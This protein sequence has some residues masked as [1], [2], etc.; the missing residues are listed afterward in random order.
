MRPRVALASETIRTLGFEF[1]RRIGSEANLETGHLCHCHPVFRGG[2][3]F[4]G[5]R[6]AHL[7]LACQACRAEAIARLDQIVAALPVRL[8]LWVLLKQ[9]RLLCSSAMRAH[10][11]WPA[12][13]TPSGA[14]RPQRSLALRSQAI[15]GG[16][17]MRQSSEVRVYAPIMEFA[18]SG[19]SAGTFTVVLIHRRGQIRRCGRCFWSRGYSFDKRMWLRLRQVRYGSKADLSV[20]AGCFRAGPSARD[21]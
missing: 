1:A 21:A 16:S 5:H 6:Q 14:C 19:S 20:A 10:H 3:G 18:K 7:G 12:P 11:A 17:L 4:H 15:F 9:R 13:A 2:R 8:K